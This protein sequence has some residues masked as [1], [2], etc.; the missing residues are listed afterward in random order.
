MIRDYAFQ[1]LLS[2]A[3]AMLSAWFA[4]RLGVRRALQQTRG[5]KAFERRLNWYERAVGAIGAH[6]DALYGLVVA[7]REGFDEEHKSRL[8]DDLLAKQEELSPVLA[9]AHLY[10]SKESA[11]AVVGLAHA[12]VSLLIPQLVDARDRSKGFRLSAADL[13]RAADHGLATVAMLGTELRAH[14]GLEP[15]S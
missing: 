10:A 4:G 14:L 1:T 12:D 15:L 8:V 6:A 3:V 5:E 7:V 2:A 9:Q 13:E 11:A